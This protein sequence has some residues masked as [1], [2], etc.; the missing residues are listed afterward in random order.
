MNEKEK[1]I[2][3]VLS[4]IYDPEIPISIYALGLIYSVTMEDNKNAN[5]QMTLTSPNCP[6]AQSLPE[7]VRVK[8]CEVEGVENTTVDIVWD[9]PWTPDMMNEAA[10]LELNL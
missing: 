10:K 5:I 9:P 3:E 6:V 7:E 1:L 2:I 8:V 4:S